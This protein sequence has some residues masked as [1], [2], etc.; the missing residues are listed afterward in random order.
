MI[1]SLL[2]LLLAPIVVHIAWGGETPSL[3][4]APSPVFIPAGDAIEGDGPADIVYTPDGTTIII[5][6]RESH[7]LILWDA[8]TL[9]FVGEIP[10]SGAA[11]S[12]AVTPDGS[13]AVVALLDVGAVS[14]VDLVSMTETQVVPVGDCPGRVKI[15]PSGDIAAVALASDSELVVFDIA[16]AMI[17]RVIPNIGFT[18]MNYVQLFTP[19]HSIWYSQFSFIDDDRVINADRSAEKVQFIN[20]RTGDVHFIPIAPNAGDLAVSADASTAAILHTSSAKK[21]TVLDLD[22]ETV[23]SVISTEFQTIFTIALSEDGSLGVVP[24]AATSELHIVDLTTGVVGPPLATSGHGIYDMATAPDG[25]HVISTGS[26]SALI[27]LDSGAVVPFDDAP[28]CEFVAVSP[29]APR[30]ATCSSLWDEKLATFSLDPSDPALLTTSFTAPGLEADRT[31]RVAISPDGSV[32]VALFETSDTLAIIDTQTKTMTSLV[33]VGEQPV[34]VAITPDNS[35]AVVANLYSDFVSVIDLTDGTST[36]APF[37]LYAAAVVISPDG[38]Y[39]Y[40]YTAGSERGVWR[41]DLETNT[42]D[43]S[44]I[45]TALAGS[46]VYIYREFSRLSLAPDGTTLAA[47]A[48]FG[49]FITFIDTTTWQDVSTAYAGDDAS[50]IAFAPDMSACYTPSK[51]DNKIRIT[52]LSMETPAWGGDISVGRDPW[53]IVAVPD[54]RLL[55]NNWADREIGIVDPSQSTQVADVSLPGVCCGMAVV[56]GSH[57]AYAASGLTSLY[58]CFD[59]EWSIAGDGWFHVIDLDSASILET[60]PLDALPVAIDFDAAASNAVIAAPFADGVFVLDLPTPCNASDLAWPFS[61]LDFSDISTFLAA[62]GAMDPIADLAAPQG[63]FDFSDVFA[64]L[65]A[66]GAG[67]P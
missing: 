30:A 22:T 64:F 49:D 46:F 11:Q 66:F 26:V 21:I 4:G 20:V 42:L 34:A 58:P 45:P 36:S 3:R 5:A 59:G 61:T 10:V 39:A 60:I 35:K 28:A 62:F 9:A 52:D 27:D 37:A 23:S 43:G 31:R 55:V 8:D 15:S 40:I 7:N 17:E 24:D 6:H 44:M 56:P 13:T 18:S 53:Q 50:W 12:V 67:C 1:R 29:V 63:V 47:V 2:Y 57:I 32:A 48:G 38:R 54:G 19:T 25:R 33:Q 16:S 51:S 14:I 41:L 65:V